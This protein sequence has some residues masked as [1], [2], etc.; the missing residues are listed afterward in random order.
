MRNTFIL[1]W[2][3]FGAH[4]WSSS[5]CLADLKKL[6]AFVHE[7]V[8]VSN[9]C[10]WGKENV[11]SALH[12]GFWRI[13]EVNPD[14][15]LGILEYKLKDKLRVICDIGNGH[16][17]PYP[18]YHNFEIHLK[19]TDSNDIKS[20]STLFHEFLH[21]IEVPYDVDVHGQDLGLEKDPVYA[22]HLTAFP[23]LL[24]NEE[25]LKAFEQT[26]GERLYFCSDLKICWDKE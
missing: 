10:L 22:C 12:T 9:S 18:H 1:A 23:E 17:Y 13:C 5:P 16:P 19:Q 7:N 11:L 6:D 21:F 15:V 26:C 8:S 20:K 4:A 3:L 24:S 25:N 2:I 14:L